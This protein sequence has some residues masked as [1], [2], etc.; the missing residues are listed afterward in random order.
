MLTSAATTE[1][2]MQLAQQKLCSALVEVGQLE[3]G[4]MSRLAHAVAH[5]TQAAVSLRRWSVEVNQRT[6][7][8]D[9]TGAYTESAVQGGLS[10][11]T[12]QALRNALLG[13]S[14]INPGASGLQDA[15]DKSEVK[16]PAVPSVAG[17]FE[18]VRR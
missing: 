8:R 2:L 7:A 10:S 13:L 5:L 4:D 15:A 6:E 16:T 12:S 1:G 18:K 3:Q 11:E 17:E 9:R 14:P